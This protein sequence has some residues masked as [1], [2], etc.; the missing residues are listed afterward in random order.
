[1][2]SVILPPESN[3]YRLFRQIVE[4]QQMVFLTGL[5]G[6]GKSL[7]LKQLALMAQQAG[8]TVHL[9][10]WDVTRAPFETAVNLAKYPEIDG[11]THAAIRKAVGLWAR[12]GIRRWH[13]KYG[14]HDQS[15]HDHFLLGEVP[16]IGNRL[17]ELAQCL[18]DE[19]EPVLAGEQTL[20]VVPV[21][22]REI[23]Q[24]IEAAREMSIAN[25]QHEKERQDAQ[26]GVLRLLWQEV[27]RIGQKLGWSAEVGPMGDV[28]YDP[29]LYTAVYLHLLTHRRHQ[30]L[31]I[32]EVL[33]P[34]GSVYDLTIH[35]TEL[36]ATPDEVEQIMQLVE[37]RFTAD[38]LETAVANWYK[39]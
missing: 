37:Q 2:R 21:P 33:Q 23:R 17:S 5:P 20:F 9:L 25:P 27:A 3:V 32:T 24:H 34:T 6:T 38:E 8:R 36:T 16:L 26:P 18:D 1:M 11:V 12:T 19:V 39:I 35:G 10:Q 31:P 22:S 7:L 28:L 30:I 14:S 15:G 13:K 4:Q 29:A